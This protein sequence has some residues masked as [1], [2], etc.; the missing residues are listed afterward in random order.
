MNAC[1]KYT[2]IILVLSSQMIFGQANSHF[3]DNYLFY[4]SFNQGRA[5]DYKNVDG[6]PYL[7]SEFKDGVIYLK[8][9]M[10]VKLPLRYNI[11]N[12]EIEYKSKEVNYVVGNPQS[13]KKILLDGSEFV[14]FPFSQEGG[15]FELF[16]SGKCMLVQKKMVEFR[17][18]EA[19]RP[20]IGIVP[21]RFVRKSDIFYLVTNNSQAFKIKNITSVIDALQDQK[22]KIESFIKQEKIKKIKKDDL[23]KIVKYYN[24]L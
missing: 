7:N 20:M 4:K 10:A 15:Y 8:D 3:I 17:P 18:S 24:S 13:L 22:L 2:I 12:D 6:S 19:E 1:K 14:Y 21:A 16:E 11:Y 9:T 23:V 5:K